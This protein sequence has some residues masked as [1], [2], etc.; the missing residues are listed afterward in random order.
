M[1]EINETAEKKTVKSKKSLNPFKNKKFK[2]G[3]LSVLFTVIFIVIVVLVNVVISLLGERFSVAA[4]LT[5]EGLYTI[6]QETEDYLA[7]ITD[8]VAITVTATESDFGS[9]SNIYLYQ[10]NA[11]LKK[12]A[13]ANDNITLDYVDIVANPGFQANFTETIS[14]GQIVV[15]SEN[16]KRFKILSQNDYLSITYNQQYMQMGYPMIESIEANCEQAVVSAI[17]N[18]TDTDPV[19][20]AVISGYGESDNP[21]AEQLLTTNSYV[22]EDVDITRTDSISEEYDFV[23]INGPKTDYS[24]KDITKID[25]WLDNGGKFGKSLF[26]ASDPGLGESPN[27]D[28]LLADWGLKVEKGT[29]YQTDMNYAYEGVYTLQSLEIPQTDYSDF[30]S[31]RPI[32]TDNTSPITEMWQAS[33]IMEVT[34]LLATHDG[35]VIKPQNAGD[36]W[37]PEDSTERTAYPVAAMTTKTRFEGN[38]PFISRVIA[39]G[40]TDMF[41]T[42]LM[43]NTNNSQMFINIF[44]ISCGKTEGITLT[45]KSYNAAVLEITD[46]QTN[47]LAVVFVIVIPLIVLVGGIFIWLRRIHK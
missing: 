18:V 16:T 38:D 37:A 39:V 44:N 36:N 19:K 15:Q 35:A 8:K 42:Y 43:T 14:Q 28:G 17:M 40:G 25:D 2:Y 4:D 32:F 47:I 34:T 10:T 12:I 7:G 1:S 5:D 21:Y 13:N 27:L 31:E 41:S 24:V 22:L 11:I 9:S 30:D 45:P 6:E 29:T 3:S 20:V 46:E 23:F 33:G 26:Y